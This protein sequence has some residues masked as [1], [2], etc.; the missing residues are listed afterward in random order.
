MP[1]INC[2]LDGCS[3]ATEDVDAAIAASLLILHNNVHLNE[4]AKCSKQKPPKIDRPHIGKDCTEE[5]WNT[6]T[7]KWTMFKE[8]TELS[9]AETLRQLFQCCDDELGDALLKGHSQAINSNEEEL[10]KTIKLLAVV[11]VSVVVRRSDF[12]ST[13]QDFGENTRSYAARL[14]GKATTCSYSCKCPKE[15]CG[16]IVDFTDI[17][18]KDVL[19]TGLADEDIR[20]DVLG[21][22]ELDDTNI[23]DTVRFIE[24]KEMARDAMNQP[25]INAAVSAYKSSQKKSMQKPSGKIVCSSCHEQT[26]K[27]VWSR[28]KNKFIEC[29][30]CMQCWRKLKKKPSTGG[31]QPTKLADE[32]S[33]LLIGSISSKSLDERPIGWDGKP[34]K[35]IKLDHYIF[36]SHDGWKVSQSLKH[37]MVQLTVSTD[38]EAY[39]K[40]NIKCP[41]PNSRRVKVVTD[42]GAQSCLWG[43]SSFL[44]CGF[45][46]SDLLPVKRSMVAANR[47]KID[48]VG[49]MFVELCGNDDKGQMHTANVMVYVSP[50]TSKFY[51]SRD[52]L[53][54]LAII[55]ND[56]P[57]IGAAMEACTVIEKENTCGCVP[58]TLPPGRPDRLPFPCVP[59]NN[60]RMK[61]WLLEQYS[62]STFNKCTHQLLP[63]MTGPPLKIHMDPEAIP[64]AISTAAPIPKHWEKE[65]KEKL[66][67]DVRLGVLGKTPIG[68][69][70]TW[71]HRM[72]VVA[73]ADGSSRRAVDLSPLNKFCVRETHH[74]KPPFIQAREIP[75]NTWKSVTDAWNGFHSVP[76]R[77][78][79]QHLTTFLTPW[80]RYYYKV[81]PQGYLASGDAYTRRYDEI[82]VDTP[83]KTKCVDDTVL[84]DEKLVDHWWRM[85]DYLEL[86]GRNGVVLN[87]EKFQFAQ[88]QIDFAGFTITNTEIKPQEKFLKA[89]RDF[90]PPKSVT[91]V[92]SWFGL[93]HQVSHYDQLTSLMAPFKP[94]LSPKTKF[95]WDETLNTAFQK[96]KHAIVEAITQGVEIFD[97]NRLTC[98]Q[99]DWSKTGIGYFLSQKHCSCDSSA[100]GCCVD[101]WRIV[102]AGSRFLKPS[103]ARYAPVEGESLAIVWALEHS[104]YFTQGCKNLLVLTDHKPLVKLFGD[105]TLDEIANPRL[106]RLKQRSLL[107]R[108]KVQHKPGKLHVA[109]DAMSRHPVGLSHDDPDITC[110]EV[111]A[112]ICMADEECVVAGINVGNE[113]HAVTWERVVEETKKDSTM[114][115]LAHFVEFGFPENKQD[116]PPELHEFWTIRAYLY[117]LDKVVMR[118]DYDKLPQLN[119]SDILTENYRVDLSRIIVPPVL[120]PEVLKVLHSAHQGVTAMNERAKTVVFWP[121]ITKDIQQTRESCSSCNLVA[122]SNPRLPPI[123]PYI[124]KVPFESIV[125]DYFHYKGWYYFVAADRL[126][127][128]TEQQRIRVGT[129]ESGATGLCNAL[130]RL[131]V[132]FGV[133]VELSSDGGPEFASRVTESFLKRWGV[134]H[135]TSSA[136]HP[137]SNGRAELAVKS[138]KRL[139]MENV[140]PNGCLENDRMVRAL[141][142][143]RNTPDPGCKLS[144]AQILL[145]RN[146]K[147]SLP[148]IRKDVMSYNNPQISNLWRE[149]W[150]KKEDALRSRYVKTMENLNEHSKSLPSLKCGDRVLIQNQCGHFPNKWGKSGV[151]VEVKDF[152]QYVVKVDGSGRLTLRNR[153]FLRRYQPPS[154]QSAVPSVPAPYI[155]RR[156]ISIPVSAEST[157][158]PDVVTIG[159]SNGDYSS[160]HQQ[161]EPVLSPDAIV[162]STSDDTSN[163]Q[164]VGRKNLLLARLAS[165]NRPGFI[166]EGRTE[167]LSD[168]EG[169]HAH[170]SSDLPRRSRRQKVPRE[171]YDANTGTFKNV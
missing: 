70:S 11:P 167:Q 123:E 134:R 88:S 169:A 66:D 127:G 98:L 48:I 28:R 71:V 20:K 7:Q 41:Q 139:L 129:T 67:T 91:D 77:P 97:L 63:E 154:L 73:K 112:G 57:R 122:P 102:L 137:S 55:G 24:A 110:S 62:S 26:D 116:L 89:I 52:A 56:F 12:L 23:N 143:Q 32:A 104:R 76:L 136:Y 141:L 101:G 2:P 113:L 121:G 33:A 40:L 96:S 107:W 147:D 152:H 80:G 65:V 44:Q 158:T 153:Q 84:W 27:Y 79:D 36:D 146:L 30:T 166:E 124:P 151:I 118:C 105:R 109:P 42:T 60:H 114:M 111:L 82:I 168:T 164:K 18:V 74:V 126:S 16:Q 10:M 148:F 160:S 125:C 47:E 120:R 37:P 14:K 9:S 31:S 53:I 106:F 39:S 86:M 59:E 17:I 87:P 138:T 130:R 6:F 119:D 38:D 3:F 128:W 43:L 34:V 140:G 135:R 4:N 117:M 171:I 35:E 68:V 144:P 95:Y 45:N 69:P 58:R 29:S 81:A 54:K 61:E 142:T 115:K 5:V 108:F 50:S 64:H 163:Q 131:F 170:H 92:R 21:W 72:I 78:E 93:V 155:S 49:A 1:V 161:A 51:L 132:T 159:D 13:R 25:S 157:S 99:P 165:H 103:E 46:Q 150:S 22:G 19:V 156:E 8:S 94:L 90:P 83:R 85:I 149:T 75:S 15:G 162:D 145:G 100:P 133:P